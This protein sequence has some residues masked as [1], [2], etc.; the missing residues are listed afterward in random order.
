LLYGPLGAKK[1]PNP[2]FVHKRHC[3]AELEDKLYAISGC[4]TN[5]V[6]RYNFIREDWE[7][8]GELQK[9]RAQAVATVYQYSIY[10][11][12]GSSPLLIEC[13]DFLKN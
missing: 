8:A 7:P 12:G 1:L 3:L 2:A 11:M 10:V 5:R 13:Y 6:E 9:A 4:Y